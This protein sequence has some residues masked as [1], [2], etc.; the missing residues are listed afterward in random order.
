[1]TPSVHTDRLGRLTRFLYDAAG[2]LVSTYLPSGE[3]RHTIY[4]ALNRAIEL[5]YVPGAG[6][7]PDTANM[8]VVKVTYDANGAGQRGAAALLL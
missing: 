7:T 1:M 8:Q 6:G 4:D 3:E 2:N 5:Q